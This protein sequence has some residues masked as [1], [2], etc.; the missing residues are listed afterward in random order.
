MKH[1]APSKLEAAILAADVKIINWRPDWEAPEGRAR[2]HTLIGLTCSCYCTASWPFDLATEEPPHGAAWIGSILADPD[3]LARLVAQSVKDRLDE[4]YHADLRAMYRM[5][6][7]DGK[8]THKDGKI[9]FCVHYEA[10]Q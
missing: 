6:S 2:R 1:H 10:T 4:Q 9:R 3:T 5:V 8:Y 7:C